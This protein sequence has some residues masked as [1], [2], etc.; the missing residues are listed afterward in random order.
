LADP[1]T[2]ATLRAI[3]TRATQV[4]VFQRHVE[5]QQQQISGVVA[6]VKACIAV[7]LL[8]PLDPNIIAYNMFSGVAYEP[9]T[10]GQIYG[11]S[12]PV[13]ISN[14]IRSLFTP[15]VTQKGKTQLRTFL[16]TVEENIEATSKERAYCLWQHFN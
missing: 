12:V 4:D 14:K 1:R 3:V 15:L 2:R 13:Y 16:Q 5:Q 7:K 9:M 6:E 10:V 11:I 8:R